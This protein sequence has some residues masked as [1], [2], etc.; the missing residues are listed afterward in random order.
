MTRPQL[1]H[2][3]SEA[4]TNRIM[5]KVRPETKPND[6]EQGETYNSRTVS[7]ATTD[8]E[9][10]EAARQWRLPTSTAPTSPAA[11]AYQSFAQA[12]DD[13]IG[14]LG[15]ANQYGVKDGLHKK[16]RKAKAFGSRMVGGKKP[17]NWEK[18]SAYESTSYITP[19]TIK[20]ERLFLRMTPKTAGYHRMFLWIRYAFSGA[21]VSAV[22]YCALKICGIIEYARVKQTT[23]ALNSGDFV[24]AWLFWVGTSLGMNVFACC[25]VLLQPA[26]ASSGIPGLIAFL[27]GVEP[28]GGKSPITNKHTSWISLKTGGAKFLGMLASIPSGL[29]IGPEGPI[30]HISALVAY[31]STT[32]VHKIEAKMFGK[33]F[34]VTSSA[35][36]RDFLATGAGCGICTAFRAPLAGTLFVVEEAGS[37]F[38]SAHLEYTFFSCLIAYWMQWVLGFYFDGPAATGVKFPQDTGFFCNVDN[39][40]NMVAYVILAIIGGLVGALFNQIV[41]TLNHYRAH[42]VNKHGWKRMAEIVF[43]TILTGTCVIFLPMAASCRLA[44]RDVMLR[45]SAGCLPVEDFAQVSYGEVSFDY[46]HSISGATQNISAFK[47]TLAEDV[48]N[49]V[50]LHHRVQTVRVVDSHLDVKHFDTLMIDNKEP[51]IH[52]HYEHVY[53]CGEDSH[54]FNEMA[55]LWLNGG[56]KGVKVLLQRGF[57]HLISEQT[58]ILF[59]C[60]YFVLAAVTAGISIPAGLVVPMLLIGGSMGR[61]FGYE[62][63]KFKTTMCN[64]YVNLAEDPT[65]PGRFDMYYWA[66][67]YRWI[68]RDCRLPDPGSFACIGM[69]SFMGGSGRITVMLAVVMLELTGDA[70]MIAPVGI[71]CVISMIVGNLFNHGLYHGLIPVMNIPFLN[72]IPAQIMYVTRVN[73]IMSSKLVVLPVIAHI[74]EIKMLQLRMDRGTVTH[75]GFP[76]VENT[77]DLHLVGLLKK[78]HI[79]QL[80]ADMKNPE[81]RRRVLDKNECI[82]LMEYCDRSPLAVTAMTTV[83][84]GYEMFRK[85]GLRHLIVL[86]IKGQVVGVITRKDLML[87][88]IVARKQRELE[89]LIK[90][91]RYLRQVLDDQGWY[92]KSGGREGCESRVATKKK[93]KVGEQ[94]IE[95]NKKSDVP[96]WL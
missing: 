24:G 89:L 41:E 8:N 75:C 47:N 3:K 22:I 38:T 35:E 20:Q 27:N 60:V 26:A 54:T 62:W 19:D 72:A 4:D 58:L 42:H 76:V 21:L 91:Q 31:W 64:D 37:F 65:A 84:R 59:F 94:K 81:K 9:S 95:W 45:D 11:A 5:N 12:R 6:V 33:D 86:G 66:S 25:L 71:V 74:N 88:R 18:Y 96:H 10:K 77:T 67:T 63:M 78:E 13:E 79:G 2:T 46:M 73:T 43:L 82:D 1:Q 28:S 40:L 36:L 15:G 50:D 32:L 49:V 87:F 61:L 17:K 92:E 53:T 34:D 85:L 16:F 48:N 93:F 51:Y 39:P 14:V 83:A 56:V 52:L 7:P 57:P 70:G 30:I 29:C 44:T 23:G 90:M 80:L 69:A 55:M 68:I